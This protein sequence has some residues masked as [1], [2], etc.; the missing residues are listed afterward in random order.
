MEGGIYAV[1]AVVLSVVF[2]FFAVKF[3]KN[4]SHENARATLLAS[5][6]F[7]TTLMI[8]MFFDKV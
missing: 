8:L 7:L 3:R 6:F 5:Y 4:P 2:I 1:G